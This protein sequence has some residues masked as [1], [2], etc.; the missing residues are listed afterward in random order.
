M[1]GHGAS[2]GDGDHGGLDGVGLTYILTSAR[3]SVREWPTR[4]MVTMLPIPTCVQGTSSQAALTSAVASAHLVAGDECP[5]ETSPIHISKWSRREEQQSCR[6][7][8]ST[9]V[10]NAR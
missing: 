4:T 1:G 2:G 10:T 7:K 9:C 6:L 8:T 3:F 5:P